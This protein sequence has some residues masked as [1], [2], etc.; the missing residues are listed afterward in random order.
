MS[1]SPQV[2]S[3]RVSGWVDSAM[4][5]E[6]SYSATGLH[7]KALG[8]LAELTATANLPTSRAPLMLETG[9]TTCGT[10]WVKWFNSTVENTVGCGIK[11]AV[12]A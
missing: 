5:E 12:R 6:Q 8:T 4:A 11:M 1:T 10:V 7:M 2:L 3:T 9:Q